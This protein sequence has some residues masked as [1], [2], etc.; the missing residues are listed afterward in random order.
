VFDALVELDEPGLATLKGALGLS[1]S[2]PTPPQA[3]RASIKLTTLIV[4]QKT[5]TGILLSACPGHALRFNCPRDVG[6]GV[7]S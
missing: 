6:H 1:V 2:T 5:F 4:I 7:H 3:V